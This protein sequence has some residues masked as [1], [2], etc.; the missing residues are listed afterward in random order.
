MKRW[1]KELALMGVTLVFI[2]GLAL[3]YFAAASASRVYAPAAFGVST[4]D[5]IKV[6]ASPGT[7]KAL[8]VCQKGLVTKGQTHIEGSNTPFADSYQ[9]VFGASVL[10]WVNNPD[11]KKTPPG[12]Q[13]M[14]LDGQPIVTDKGVQECMVSRGK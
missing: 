11:F 13:T 10:K 14:I 7:L 5:T 8:E 1:A 4:G 9:A 6:P 2:A 3:G 12:N